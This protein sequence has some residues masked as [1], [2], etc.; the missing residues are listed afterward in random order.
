MALVALCD[1]CGNPIKGRIH[2]VIFKSSS[3]FVLDAKAAVESIEQ[4][5]G[6]NS[7]IYC[8][9]CMNK[10]RKSLNLREVSL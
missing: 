7:L 10:A 9:E 8:T 6:F 3:A 4:D 5:S 1:C 2:K